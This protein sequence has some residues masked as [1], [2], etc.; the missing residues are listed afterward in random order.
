[1]GCL[2]ISSSSRQNYVPLVQGFPS[3][4][5]VKE[6]YSPLKKHYFDPIG[7][8]SVKMVADR[9]THVAYHNEHW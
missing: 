1:M 3:N 5:G 2:K 8:F 9:Y 6:R 4:E 7:S